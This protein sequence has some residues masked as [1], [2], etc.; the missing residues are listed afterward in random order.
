MPRVDAAFTVSQSV[1]DEYRRRYGVEMAVV[2]N[3]PLRIEDREWR[4]ENRPSAAA[5]SQFSILNSQ[6][7][8]VPLQSHLRECIAIYF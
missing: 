7:F 1:A 8:F 5:N 2:R 3:M 6:L 4:M